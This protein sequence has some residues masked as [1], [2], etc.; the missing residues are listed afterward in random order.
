MMRILPRASQEWSSSGGDGG[1]GSRCGAAGRAR[2]AQESTMVDP[3]ASG[4][5]RAAGSPRRSRP[6]VT[7]RQ[8]TPPRQSGVSAAQAL[9]LLVHALAGVAFAGDLEHG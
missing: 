1:A 5:A 8:V 6:P 9:A 7:T 3:A 4:H 2:L